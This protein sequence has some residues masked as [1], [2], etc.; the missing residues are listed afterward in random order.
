MLFEIFRGNIVAGSN[1]TSKESVGE[2]VAAIETAVY[3][4]CGED[5]GN[6]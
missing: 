5:A 2:V 6:K 3:Q 4:D 1:Q